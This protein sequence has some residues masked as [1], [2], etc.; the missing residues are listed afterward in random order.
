MVWIVHAKYSKGNTGNE[1][2][3]QTV[4]EHLNIIAVSDTQYRQ[5]DRVSF[6]WIQ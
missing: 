6:A 1:N 2:G 3:I 4:S 5:K